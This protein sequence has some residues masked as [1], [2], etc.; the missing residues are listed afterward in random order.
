MILREPEIEFIQI[1]FNDLITNSDPSGGGQRC[2]ASQ[3][4]AHDCESWETDVPWED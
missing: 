3:E 1:D 4:D 2:V